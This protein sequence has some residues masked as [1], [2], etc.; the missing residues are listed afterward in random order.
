VPLRFIR[1][2]VSGGGVKEETHRQVA[3]GG[4]LETFAGL[5][6]VPRAGSENSGLSRSRGNRQ[7]HR[8]GNHSLSGGE[9]H[10]HGG[11]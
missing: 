3:S 7:R 1:W 4:G 8:R 10:T 5:L 11:R 9:N 2:S 6:A